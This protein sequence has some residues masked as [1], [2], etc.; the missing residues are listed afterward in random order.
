M[1]LNMMRMV[2]DV[3]VA[4]ARCEL[5]CLCRRDSRSGGKT[6]LCGAA[7]VDTTNVS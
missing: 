3:A 7:E 4:V 6:C 1:N 2:A 5:E